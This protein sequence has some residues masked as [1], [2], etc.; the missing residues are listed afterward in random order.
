MRARVGAG[1]MVKDDSLPLCRRRFV[2][3]VELERGRGPA[4]GE[5]VTEP[6]RLGG[7][8]EKG[9][10]SEKGVEEG[11]VTA[12]ELRSGIFIDGVWVRA[13]EL[14]EASGRTGSRRIGVV[15]SEAGGEYLVGCLGRGAGFTAAVSAEEVEGGTRSEAGR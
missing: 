9:S 12:R 4:G 2:C 13:G 8:R 11:T 6:Q 1:E 5:R 14:L 7:E 3:A 10:E 15:V